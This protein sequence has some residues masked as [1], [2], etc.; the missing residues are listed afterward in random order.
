MNETKSFAISFQITKRKVINACIALAVMIAFCLYGNVSVFFALLCATV[1]FVVKCTSLKLPEKLNYLWL[2]LEV[3]ALS[4]F[5]EWIIQFSLLDKELREKT[6]SAK[7]I[8]NI[9]VCMAIYAAFLIIW[10]NV[11]KSLMTAYIC[12]VSF[13]GIDYFVYLFRGNE[14]IFADLKSFKTGLSVLSEYKFSLS[15]NAT[16]T[17]VLSI[18]MV[19]L[20]RL[21]R[22]KFERKFVLRSM[23]LLAVVI[24]TYRIASQTAGV[25]TES[26]EQKGTYRNG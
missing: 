23:C 1:Y 18:V 20:I 3:T 9:L 7:T 13:A 22:L 25:N 21:I 24:C 8:L 10:T 12:M 16:I 2:V 19:A 5:T 4:V 11:V 6:T 15:E 26:W 17:I 14:L